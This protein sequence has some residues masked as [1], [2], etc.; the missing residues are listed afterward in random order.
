[1]ACG[2]HRSFIFFL[3]QIIWMIF[4]LLFNGY[5]VTMG[6]DPQISVYFV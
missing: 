5:M 2:Q 4:D 3:L 6:F 1:M